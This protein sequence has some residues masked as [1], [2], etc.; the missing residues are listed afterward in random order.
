MLTQTRPKTHS[1]RPAAQAKSRPTMTDKLTEICD[2]KRSEVATR[3]AATSLSDL[4]TRAAQQ[5]PPR[6]FEAA[7]RAKAAT[8]Y[9]L[10]AE[11]KKASPSKGL[12]RP[13]FSPQITPAPIRRAVP[14][15]SRSS[16]MHPIF[17]AT[18]IT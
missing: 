16:R 8:G 7:L 6:G 15:A 17:R 10:I 1:T 14:P 3:K 9:A 11:I 4:A 13:D 18:K 5:T 12:I 2:T